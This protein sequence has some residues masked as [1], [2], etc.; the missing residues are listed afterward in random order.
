MCASLP[1][2]EAVLR[3]L[4]GRWCLTTMEGSCYVVVGLIY[5]LSI[6]PS[7]VRYD[8]AADFKLS[9]SFGPSVE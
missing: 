3:R 7:R 1:I 4:K 8:V 2:L 6:R 9:V 5:D